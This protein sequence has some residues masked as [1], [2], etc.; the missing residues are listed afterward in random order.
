[1]VLVD[2]VLCVFF[3]NAVQGYGG[4]RSGNC[5]R[6]IILQGHGK[7][8]EFYAESE[9]IDISKESQGRLKEFN[10]GAWLLLKVG[11]DIWIQFGFS[12]IFLLDEEGKFLKTSHFQWISGKEGYR[13]SLYYY[14]WH[15]VF[16]WSGKFYFY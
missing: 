14:I 12:M 4:H 9:K 1:M 11:R 10:I 5:Q 6:K 2:G 15:F 3:F 8:G 13:R 7:A 16:N